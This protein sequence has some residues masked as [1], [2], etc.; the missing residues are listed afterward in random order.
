[1]ER[2]GLRPPEFQ[3]EADSLFTVILRNTPFYSRETMHWLSGFEGQNLSGNQKRLLAYAREHGG[4]V[5]SRAYQNLAHVD[6]YTASH[7]I[8]SLLGKG[9]LRLPKKGGRVYELIELSADAIPSKPSDYIALEPLLTSQGFIKS[10]DI[11]DT[12]DVPLAQAW[13]IAKR[14]V[15]LGWLRPVGQRKARSYVPAR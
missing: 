12:L 15:D 13:R 9:I 14:L 7:D 11:Q 8:R 2:E 10:Q 5:T 6:L 3:V 1:M 4:T